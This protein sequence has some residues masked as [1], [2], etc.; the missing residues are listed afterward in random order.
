MKRLCFG[1]LLKLL[2]LARNN[3]TK[4]IP[5]C[6]SIF[7][8]YG[9]DYDS[10]VTLDN[11]KVGHLKSGHDNL[12]DRF[13]KE[14]KNSK[15]ND[16]VNGFIANVIP[17]IKVEYKPNLVLAIRDIIK[18]DKTIE[19]VCKL[20]N[21]NGYEKSVIISSDK[22]SL[23]L[24]LVCAFRFAICERKNTECADG[25]EG[26]DKKYLDG[27]SKYR[28][29]IDLIDINENS[30][31]TSITSSI[32]D[33]NF[34]NVFIKVTD[35]KLQDDKISSLEIYRL[36]IKSGKFRFFDLINFLSDN[37]NKYVFSRTQIEEY[38]SKLKESRMGM[39]ALKTFSKSVES[40][41]DDALGELLIYIFLEQ[42]LKAPKLMSTIELSEGKVKS[43]GVH[44]L[45]LKERDRI[46]NQI[47]FGASNILDDY[48]AAI[49]RAFDK[50]FEIDKAS[51][52]G[53]KI[54]NPKILNSKFDKEEASYLKSIIVPSDYNSEY[55]N[56]FGLFIGYTL[57]L[58]GK[59]TPN[60]DEIEKQLKK[61]IE[62]MTKYIKNKIKTNKLEGIDFYIYIIPFN[63]ASKDKVAVID[64]MIK[65]E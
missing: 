25:T 48:E 40:S 42:V 30:N 61:D 36:N 14:V 34:K 22:F 52:N 55:E 64:R 6:Q 27:F 1:S 28:N 53:L 11:A 15:N 59:S 23:E 45:V 12:D 31:N 37:L 60:I 44:L 51:N 26:I 49:D 13:I 56:A 9:F 39:D 65:D 33:E 21:E 46:I 17:N 43:D 54:I 24:L 3:G 16:V 63:E 7:D 47:V 19:D 20:G 32:F 57:S 38:K 4:N 50:I 62:K 29:T 10:I 8:A 35:E 41:K 2:Y 58:K 5:L 18:E